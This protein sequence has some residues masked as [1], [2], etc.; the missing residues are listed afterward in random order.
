[1]VQDPA[2]GDGIGDRPR[3]L[4]GPPQ[5]LQTSGFALAE[6][7]PPA[8]PRVMYAPRPE[9]SLMPRIKMDALWLE[10]LKPS[11]EGESVDAKE[12]SST[13]QGRGRVM[14]T[15]F[16]YALLVATVVGLA[17][18]SAVDVVN[19]SGGNQS[20]VIWADK[21]VTTLQ[22][23]ILSQ[24]TGGFS[25]S[26]DGAP[27]GGFTPT[28][29][30]NVTVSAPAPPCFDGGTQVTGT[31][32]FQH[33]L[34]AKGN[35]SAP[36]ISVTS[37]TALFVPPSLSVTPQ[38]S[39]ALGLNQSK[40]I[41]VA[42]VPG[43]T[44]PLPVTLRPNFPTVSVDG[45]PAGTPVSKVFPTNA[46]GTFQVTGVSLGSFIVRIEGQGVQCGGTSGFVS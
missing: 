2:D 13:V 22:V 43:P 17:C 26:L 3:L 41:T 4:S 33:D 32:R 27:I 44:A 37:D 23:K 45:A 31:N 34:S 9:V 19:P 28:P 7:L 24:Y 46:A 25:A 20:G 8:S 12:R 40:T 11:D 16:Q 38:G 15:S 6:N 30:P 21:P 29:A 42:L 36:G 10:K 5:G 35:S 14:R 39:V 18:C 1:M